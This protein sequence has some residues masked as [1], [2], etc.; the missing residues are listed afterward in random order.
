MEIIGKREHIEALESFRRR[1]AD[2]KLVTKEELIK[3]LK[4]I[5]QLELVESTRPGNAGA[6]G[7]TIEDLLGIKE[8]N[9]PIPDAAEWELKG[10]RIGTTSLVTFF[11]LEPSP[12]A[13]NLVAALLLPKY[14]WRH[15]EAGLR[16]P[17]TELSFRQ[18]I[19]GSSRTDRGFGVDVDYTN[20][21]VAVSF[22][23]KNVHERH[24]AWKSSVQERVGLGELDPQPYWGFDDLFHKAGTKLHNCFF[25][26]AESVKKNGREYFRYQNI[27][28]LQ[29]LSL[30]RFIKAIE[31]GAVYI[32]FDARTGHNHGTKFRLRRERMPDLYGTVTAIQ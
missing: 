30:D 8:N 16:Y 6:V 24:S 31:T 32:D 19:N 2:I 25:V 15:K 1:Y 11:H 17:E 3:A 23:E 28:M 12:R 14:G 27:L 4:T 21:K 13:A 22:D 5:C 7:N 29:Q 18:T 10:Q 20:R 26:R 9:L